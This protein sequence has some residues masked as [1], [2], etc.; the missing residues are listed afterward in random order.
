MVRYR[1]PVSVKQMRYGGSIRGG[2][3]DF[4]GMLRKFGQLFQGGIDKIAPLTSKLVGPALSA[5]TGIKGIPNPSDLG[6]DASSLAALKNVGEQILDK[7]ASSDN[8]GIKI[9]KKAMGKGLKI[10]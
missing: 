8:I 2:S 6:M 9:L 1:G 4:W 10:A 7:N 3:F 5:V